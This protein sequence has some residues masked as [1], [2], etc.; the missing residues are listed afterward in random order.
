MGNW[1]NELSSDESLFEEPSSDCI[2]QL[3]R[4]ASIPP[5][6][7]VTNCRPEHES[8]HP[9]E[10]RR[11]APRRYSWPGCLIERP[12]AP[13]DQVLSSTEKS[14]VFPL[15]DGWNPLDSGPHGDL[16]PRIRS[17]SVT[18]QI[19]LIKSLSTE[20]AL[21]LESRVFPMRLLCAREKI[22]CEW[23]LAIVDGV[24]LLHVAQ[25]PSLS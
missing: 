11:D 23:S 16:G 25:L 3:E 2:M 18:F 17:C 1:G 24:F 21:V 13:T 4:V 5:L 8:C 7:E 9:T 20:L 15:D 19:L 14:S 12:Y 22:P 10:P 6:H